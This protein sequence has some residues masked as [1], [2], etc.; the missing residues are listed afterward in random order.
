MKVG[1]EKTSWTMS[2]DL[3]M[4]R[5][6]YFIL[7][8]IIILI[9]FFLPTSPSFGLLNSLF[10]YVSSFFLH[11]FKWLLFLVDLY[12]FIVLHL[13][14]FPKTLDIFLILSII[15]TFSVQVFSMPSLFRWTL[16][17]FEINLTIPMLSYVPLL[18]IFSVKHINWNLTFLFS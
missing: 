6:D 17:Y 7:L 8:H 3:N 15:K 4:V 11:L 9:F 1:W 10:F 14:V 13:H 5:D 16:F 18:E 12:H 2:T